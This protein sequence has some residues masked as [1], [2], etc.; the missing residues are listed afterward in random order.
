VDKQIPTAAHT[1]LVLWKATRAVEAR[2]LQSIEDVGL[3]ASDF[4]ILETLLHKGPLP[5]NTL[6]RKLLLTTG[7]ITTAV[8]RLANRG[9]V[10]RKG[11]PG[12]RRV[13][14]VALTPKGRQLIRPAFARHQDDLEKVVSVLTREERA[15]LV[16]LL[17]KLGKGA[18]GAL[19]DREA[20][21]DERAEDALSWDGR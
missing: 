15:T 13:R 5:V 14:L 21:V 20:S 10:E 8:D 4:G 17:R 7:S 12:D 3:C 1:W 9:L 16:A 11:D 18:E 2:A 19:D 6:G